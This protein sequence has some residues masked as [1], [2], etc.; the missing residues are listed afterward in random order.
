MCLCEA[1]LFRKKLLWGASAKPST[2]CSSERPGSGPSTNQLL[3]RVTHCVSPCAQWEWKPLSLSEFSLVPP[4]GPSNSE[5]SPL[6]L[7]RDLTT[8]LSLGVAESAKAP[9][10]KDLAFS[11]LYIPVASP[12][13]EWTVGAQ[14]RCIILAPLLSGHVALGKWLDFSAL[15]VHLPQTD[16]NTCSTW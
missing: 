6:G 8:L 12:R 5:T 15:Q 11:I 4:V 1:G 13:S 10:G 3:A 7:S 2:P 14:G 9:S 16:N